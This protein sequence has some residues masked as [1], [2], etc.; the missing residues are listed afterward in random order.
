[1]LQPILLSN[2]QESTIIHE[3]RFASRHH[4]VHFFHR[5]HEYL[6]TFPDYVSR[7]NARRVRQVSLRAANFS[8]SLSNVP[9][10]LRANISDPREPPCVDVVTIL[11]SV[12]RSTMATDKY[13]KLFPAGPSL[14][15]DLEIDSRG[16]Q[17]GIH[18]FL[19]LKRELGQTFHP[20]GLCQT[21]S[22]L[23]TLNISI[24]QP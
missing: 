19:L 1:M 2:L 9:P 14:E 22:Q 8:A 13:S 18:F 12:S 16:A 24:L 4:L 6:A 15:L 21:L 20:S 10:C 5:G 7:V 17:F 23:I 11:V 3:V